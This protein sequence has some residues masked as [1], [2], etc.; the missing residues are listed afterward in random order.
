MNVYTNMSLLV[1]KELDTKVHDISAPDYKFTRIY[2][3]TGG[4]TVTPG[5]STAE[6][7]FEIPTKPINL[8]RSTITWTRSILAQGAGNF[9]W[10]PQDTYGEI[11][12]I[13]LLTQRG[14]EIVKLD[15]APSNYLKV[16]RKKETPY[17][18]YVDNDRPDQLYRSDSLAAVNYTGVSIGGAT[19][20]AAIG[21][22]YLENKYH[23]ISG[24][25]AANTH[26]VQ[27]KLSSILNTIFSFN[28]DI[29]FPEIILLRIIWS[30]AKLGWLTTSATVPSTGAAVF[31]TMPTFTS[32]TLN[33][34]VET[35]PDIE[36]A[37]RERLVS[38]YKLLIPFVWTTKTTTTAATS[39]NVSVKYS[40]IHGSYLRKIIHVPFHTTE[41][42]NTMYDNNNYGADRDTTAK[43]TTYYTSLDSQRKQDFDLSC[44][45]NVGT[46]YMYHK[47]MIKGSALLPQP[48][49]SANWFHCDDFLGSSGPQDSDGEVPLIGGLDLQ[50][51]ERKWDFTA[52]ACISAAYNHYT[53]AVCARW[54]HFNKSEVSFSGSA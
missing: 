50:G 30:N 44:S 37:L 40:G 25:N 5:S 23:L 18:E 42:L 26:P 8:A 41:T 33:L 31:A 51:A 46:D 45:L 32:L 47:H 16:I 22:S 11:Q 10:I 15:N 34:A 35:R 54:L 2:P 7:I 38:G 52:T 20:G 24:D 12:S 48:S 3:Q 27:L 39:L 1:T 14:V 17:Q 36:R 43:M 4:Q 53:W 21:G 28:K 29:V 9:T 19:T 6:T 49:F 13:T